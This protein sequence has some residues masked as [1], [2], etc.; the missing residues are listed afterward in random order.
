MNHYASL[1][2]HGENEDPDCHYDVDLSSLAGM[3]YQL[4]EMPKATSYLPQNER[5]D[6]ANLPE[7]EAE[8]G[9]SL[10]ARSHPPS[11][12]LGQGMVVGA[13]LK[14]DPTSPLVQGALSTR[15]Q[16]NPSVWTAIERSKSI[17]DIGQDLA[18]QRQIIVE[19]N[20]DLSSLEGAE[21]ERQVR[22]RGSHHSFAT[23]QRSSTGLQNPPKSSY[24]Y[25]TDPENPNWRPASMRPAYILMLILVSLGMSIFQE[26]FC[27]HSL[28]M[29]GRGQGIIQFNEVSSV[30]VWNFFAWKYLPTLIFVTYGVLWRIMDFDIKRLEPYYQLSQP[31]G[32]TAAASLNLDHLT[33]PNFIVP[34]NAI[35][36]KQWAV[37]CSSIGNILATSIAPS[38]QNPSVTFAKNGNCNPD[39]P[40]G[41]QK[42]LVLIVPAWSRALTSSLVVTAFIGVI[43]FIQLRRT[44][45]LLSDPKGI[46]GVA[47]M[48]TKSH[49][50]ADFQGTDEASRRG[51]HKRLQHRCFVL[52]KSSI[53]P[54]EWNGALYDSQAIQGSEHTHPAMLR[55]SVG[56]WFMA[57][58]AVCLI[59]IPIVN[60]TPARVIP[61]AA[62]WLPVL[63]ATLIKMLW[64]TLES[65]VRMMEPFYILSKGKAPPEKSITLD[66]QGTVYGWLPFKAGW[67]GHFLVALVGVS[68][69]L[70]DILTVTVSSFSVNSQAFLHKSTDKSSSSQD[71]T[72]GSFWGSVMLSIAIL[73]FV[74]ISAGLVYWR[75]RHPFLPRE[76]ST[77]AS[78]LA[79]IYASNML[80]DF[81]DTERF[82]HHEMETMLKSKGKV[83]GLGWYKGR[84]EQLHC[85][86]DEGEWRSKYEHGKSYIDSQAPWAGGYEPAYV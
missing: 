20:E 41:Q 35:R 52:Y 3:G 74:I 7:A 51:I 59:L 36:L 53:W 2:E 77:I 71:E 29:E 13:Q 73:A 82:T 4:T 38:L 49:I 58:L 68:S 44:S 43:L 28:A 1:D 8:S 79:F 61:K 57:G 60:F 42:F 56:V 16:A 21:I 5:Q 76:P 15:L 85:A 64:T 32:A 31:H 75:R 14:L 67:N 63:L 40:A 54:G 19:V 27:R 23:M 50:L 86:V 55:L 70:L 22:R 62:P 65:H 18:Q 9:D 25:P 48:A 69:V 17:R 12:K 24:Y 6:T 84:D 78:V 37:L 47:S 10:V 45:G 81:I 33:A 46:A 80:D 26:W 30:P 11:S 39:C 72:F 83:Y 66:Y 34:F